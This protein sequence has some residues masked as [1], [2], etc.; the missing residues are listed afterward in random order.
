MVLPAQSLLQHPGAI[1]C[2]QLLCP[3]ESIA[4]LT[5]SLPTTPHDSTMAVEFAWFELVVDSTAPS[6]TRWNKIPNTNAKSYLPNGISTPYGGFYMRAVRQ[7]GTLPYIF[8]NIVSVKELN[9]N[10]PECV[11][12]TNAPTYGDAVRIAPNPASEVLLVQSDDLQHPLAGW[13]LYNQQGALLQSG[14][15]EAASQLQLDVSAWNPGMYFL[16]LWYSDGKRSAHKW[17]KK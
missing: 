6:G 16:Q 8:S 14:R 5:E 3:N 1:C 13:Q 4:V 10:N 17:V 9:Q 12:S 15:L 11:S 7:V 2:D